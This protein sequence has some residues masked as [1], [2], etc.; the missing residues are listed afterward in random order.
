MSQSSEEY[1]EALY[2]LTHDGQ[3]ASTTAISKRLKIAPPSVSE[4]LKKL[5]DDGYVNYQPY[6]GVSLTPKGFKI[7][8][9]MARKHRLLER[10]LHDMLGIGKEKVHKEACALEHALSDE[11]AR[12]LCQMLKCPDKC[13]DDGN[14]IPPCDLEF[15]TCEECQRWEGQGLTEVSGRK[16]NVT[17]MLTLKEHQEGTIAFIRGDNRVLRRL[18]DMGLTPGTRVRVTKIAPPKGPME[19]AVRG[20][21]LAIGEG[22]A[23]NV[24]VE[25]GMSKRC[26]WASWASGENGSAYKPLYRLSQLVVVQIAETSL[27]GHFA[28][29]HHY[30]EVRDFAEHYHL[31]CRGCGTVFEI[32]PLAAE[33]MRRMVEMKAQ[34]QITDIEI[35]MQ[36]YCHE[37][38]EKKVQNEE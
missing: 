33:E 21:K 9:K 5:S 1:L 13:P 27:R 35:N 30:Y 31:V 38:Q 28:E 36:G 24:F 4:M 2:T 23:A 11:T 22:I 25:G 15:A 16:A 14:P 19:V 20:S 18:M 8:E 17:S 32:E 37:C 6:Q 10:F 7:A 29:D 26:W 3:T 34:F 12:S